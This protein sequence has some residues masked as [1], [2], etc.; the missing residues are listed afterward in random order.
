MR[1]KVA[2]KTMLRMIKTALKP[3]IKLTVPAM[4]LGLAPGSLGLILPPR[5]PRYEG[6]RGRTQGDRNE[7]SPAPKAKNKER[8]SVIR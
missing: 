5:M 3:R 1:E 8:F 4:S 6:I 2:E 7:S